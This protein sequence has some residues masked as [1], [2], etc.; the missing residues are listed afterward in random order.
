MASRRTDPA[1]VVADLE[2][3]VVVKAEAAVAGVVV[4]T[5]DAE[6]GEGGAVAR[7]RESPVGTSGVDGVGDA[8]PL[9]RSS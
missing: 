7:S 2:M 4:E 6:V 3:H 1:E 5:V 9:T 8:D